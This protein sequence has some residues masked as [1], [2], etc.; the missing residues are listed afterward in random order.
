MPR[1]YLILN[2]NFTNL[3][4][5]D[6]EESLSIQSIVNMPLHLSMLWRNIPPDLSEIDAYIEP[7]KQ[8]LVDQAHP[9][10]YV[11]IQG[12]FG[13]TFILVRF[14]LSKQLVPIYSTTNREAVEE[15]QNGDTVKLTRYMKHHRFRKYGV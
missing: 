1:L 14:A 8:W 2:H 4:K 3:Q 13:A 11:L 7:I 6:A 10:D 5:L 12:D 15:Q 9:S